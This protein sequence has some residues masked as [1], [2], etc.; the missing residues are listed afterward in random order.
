[1]TLQKY[2]IPPND[3]QFLES[4]NFQIPEVARFFNIPPHKLKDLTKSSFS[5]IEQEQMSFVTDC[6]LPWVVRLEQNYSMQLLSP[7]D[8]SLSGYGRLYWKHSL[9]GLLRGDSAARAT[10]YNSLFNVGALSPNDIRALEDLDPIPGGNDH[11]V[12]LNMVPL[13]MVKEQFKQKLLTP[14]LPAPEQIP[15]KGNGKDA[16][17]SEAPEVSDRE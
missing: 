16:E 9:E 11:F 6:I 15:K 13:S 14:K 4:R 3:C 2:G 1:M 17:D 8:K 12:P 7:S 10:L 5:N